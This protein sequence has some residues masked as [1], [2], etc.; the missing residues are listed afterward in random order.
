MKIALLGLPQSGKKT[1]FTLLTGRAVPEGRK[2]GD[3]LEGISQ[4]QDD[5][6]DR[7]AEIF[8]PEKKVYAENNYMLCPGVIEGTGNAEWMNVARRAD[9]IC[10]VIRAFTDDDVYHPSGSVN[11]ERDRELLEAE[12]LLADMQIIEKR[13]LKIEKEKRAG[14]TSDQVLEEHVLKKC[15]EALE[16][17]KKVSSV[18]LQPHEY[19]K[20]RSLELLTA[21]PVMNIYNVSEDSLQAESESGRVQVSCSI[22]KEIMDI[23]DAAERDEFMSSLGI[24]TSGLVRV[25]A[26]A[27]DAL[28]LMSFYT[29]GKDE[30]RAWTIRKGSSAP[31]AAGKIHTDIQRGFIRVE[32]IKY[33]DLI[34]AGSEHKAKEQGKLQTNGKDYI[35]KD[36][37]ICHYLFNV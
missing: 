17:S 7:L 11:P 36:G 22:E 6:V 13:L 24:E 27:Y 8:K 29:V 9:L 32:V 2:P 15:M 12:L 28:G 18:E 14:Q 10:M 25:N 19:A 37:D 31:E 1:L 3:V 16:M 4:I 26:A 30:C 34:A 35:L 5:R 33:D 23:E 20:I 21:I